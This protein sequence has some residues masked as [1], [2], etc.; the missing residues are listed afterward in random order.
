MKV[1]LKQADTDSAPYDPQPINVS[2][3]QRTTFVFSSH[4]SVILDER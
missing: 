4:S 1:T 2:L 3:F